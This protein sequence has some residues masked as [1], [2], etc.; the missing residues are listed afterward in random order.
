MPALHSSRPRFIPP[1]DNVDKVVRS[2]AADVRLN[3]TFARLPP[4]Q[5]ADDDTEMTGPA[6]E[7][8]IAYSAEVEAAFSQ[9]VPF[10]ERRITTHLVAGRCQVIGVDVQAHTILNASLRLLAEVIVHGIFAPHAA[11]HTPPQ[12]LG[13][14]VTVRFWH[15]HLNNACNRAVSPRGGSTLLTT[16][17]AT[18]PFHLSYHFCP[19]CPWRLYPL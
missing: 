5:P 15:A 13:P 4:T 14:L 1:T 11:T 12:L 9:Y 8:E 7:G 10:L 16:W 2:T 18:Y 3:N 17:L 19:P 6:I